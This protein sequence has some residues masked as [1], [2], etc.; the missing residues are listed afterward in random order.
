MA[1]LGPAPLAA[2]MLAEMGAHVLRIDRLNAG[3]AFLNMAPDI[4]ID[5]HGRDLL[6]ADLKSEAG[7]DAMRRIVSKADV[8][9]EGYRPGVMERLGLGPEAF[10]E[11]NPRLVYARM[12]GFGQEGPLASRAGHDLTYIA[13]AGVL[14]AIGHIGGRPVPPLNL[15]GDY[16][17][18]TMFLVTGILAALVE[19]SISGHR[20]VGDAAMVDGAPMFAAPFFGFTH[21]GIQGEQRGGNLLD[22][23]CPFYDTYGC[24]DSGHIAIAALEP[25]FFA[26]LAKGLGLEQ[27]FVARQYD[28]TL[29]AELRTEI[30]AI[31][32]TKTRDEW[33]AHFEATDACVAPVLTFTEAARHPHNVARSV[34]STGDFVR[35]NPAPRFARTPSNRRGLENTVNLTDMLAR[36]GFTHR[37]AGELEQA[38]VLRAGRG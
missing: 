32:A 36:F 37:E 18:G 2:L 33:A 30:T 14:N 34:H 3:R 23:G 17:G 21:A 11:S 19:R 9:I 13:L 10:A 28:R 7:R 15:V 26:E 4:D 22:S 20:Q 27:R 31:V 29:W 5:R 25:Q 35:P 6:A 24:S 12:T 8:L 1:V 38:G 16:G